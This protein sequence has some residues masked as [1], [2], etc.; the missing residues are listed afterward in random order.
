M[1]R[2]VR[3]TNLESRDARAKLKRRGKP[4]WRAIGKG[5]HVGYRKNRPGYSVWTGRRRR[6]DG[7]YETFEIG[8]ADDIVDANGES[9]LDFWQA[10]E[11]ARTT[12]PKSRKGVS[13]YLVKHA[14]SDYVLHLGDKQ[15]A[16]GI[17]YRLAAY[18]EPLMN[19]PVAELTT[20][21]LERW[22]RDMAKLP[23]RGRTPRGG[24][25]Q[26]RTIDGEE[27]ERK[28]KV[29]ANKLRDML[30]S[31]LNHAF[32]RGKVHDNSAWRRLKPFKGVAI[33]RSRFLTIAE[34]TRLLNA[35][36][37]DFRVLVRA[38]L[39]T[40]MRVG[41]LRR[42]QVR[43]LNSAAGTLHVR[44]SKTGRDRHVILTSDAVAFFVQLATG[45][46]GSDLLLGREWT[47]NQH[48]RLIR[49][50]CIRASIEPRVVF[51]E[52]RHTYASLCVMAAVP[53]MV[54]AR[55]LGHSDTRQVE[56]TYGHLAPGYVA[57]EIRKGAPRF[58][59]LD[60]TNVRS[61]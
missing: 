43:D 58:G 24:P 37:G 4:Y 36:D 45:R 9:V 19:R 21:E 49:E 10:Q 7:G 38:G 8:L 61:M 30:N 50:A 16:M 47:P 59:P 40:G 54:V 22:H 33:P 23:P 15:S 51:H 28:R 52:L 32:M 34:C 20:E 56:K 1:G 31:C 11:V 57:D 6:D 25:Q 46:R 12:T 60:P 39:E 13:A 5:L 17:K 26:Y 3:D 55:N 18:C 42:L 29:S 53:L 44:K 41:E 48:E 14:V 35:C 27:G 2:R